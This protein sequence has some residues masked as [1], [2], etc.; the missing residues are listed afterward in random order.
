M[1]RS[2][3]WTIF[4]LVAI[5]QFMVVLDTAIINVALPP[6]KNDL[7]FSDSSIPGLRNSGTAVGF[8]MDLGVVRSSRRLSRLRPVPCTGRRRRGGGRCSCPS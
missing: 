8:E 5:A 2:E 4:A 3:Q 6:I 7:G 1:K